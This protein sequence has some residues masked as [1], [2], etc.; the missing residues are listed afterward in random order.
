MSVLI[1]R[2]I[3]T[4]GLTAFVFQI[5]ITLTFQ[6]DITHSLATEAKKVKEIDLGK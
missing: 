5:H 3:K 1:F 6:I 4:R 2:N